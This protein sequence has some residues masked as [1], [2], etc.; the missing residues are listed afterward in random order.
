MARVT[1]HVDAEPARYPPRPAALQVE[2]DPVPTAAAEARA[3]LESFAE[4]VPARAYADLRVVVTELV[5]NG[6]KYGPGKPI[7]LSVA[8]GRGGVLRGEVDDGGTGG[9]RI[10]A[11]GP[12]GGGLGLVIVDALAEWGVYPGSS[13]VWFELR[14]ARD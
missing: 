9:V 3:A 11:P 1:T 10:R 5:T 4:S 13:H 12:L 8:L 7:E 2:F 14:P 6:V